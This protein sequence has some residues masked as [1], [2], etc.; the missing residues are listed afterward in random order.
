MSRVF[1]ERVLV[2]VVKVLFIFYIILLFIRISASAFPCGATHFDVIYI[3]SMSF[4]TEQYELFL[5]RSGMRVQVLFII[6]SK[7]RQSRSYISTQ[8]NYLYLNSIITC[9]PT[10][11]TH[12]LF[13]IK[14][15][16]VTT[17]DNAIFFMYLGPNHYKLN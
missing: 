7:L 12:F 5:D 17:R 6:S 8:F 2:Q 14:T 1:Q 10:F 13:T 3:A 15:F 4:K 9:Y 11:S 16:F